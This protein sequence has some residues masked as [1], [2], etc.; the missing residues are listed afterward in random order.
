VVGRKAG[1]AAVTRYADLATLRRN[2]SP[3]VVVV[4]D[5]TA[6]RIAI[7][8]AA[9]DADANER[10]AGDLGAETVQALGATNGAPLEHD[11]Q[12]ALF[13]W[14]DA[15]Q[16][17]HPELAMLFA[18][19]NGGKRHIATA[20]RL[21]AEGLQSGVPDMMLAVARGRF[22]GLFIELK[23]CRKAKVQREQHEWIDALRYYGYQAMICHGCA[24]AQQAIMA[25]LGQD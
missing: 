25:Y 2:I 1:G 21:K 10:N 13:A 23:R 20:R 22:H 19:P 14:A 16:A 17:Q 11:E 12:V 15:M 3:D 24:E 6:R 5:D 18:I 7:G 4:D 8:L 9:L